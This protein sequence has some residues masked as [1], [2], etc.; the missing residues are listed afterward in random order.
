MKLTKTIK[1]EV[2]ETV[3]IFCN[4]C[5]NSCKKEHGFYGLIETSFSSGYESIFPD[6]Y[7]YTFSLCEGCLLKM[8][9]QFKIEAEAK[10]NGLL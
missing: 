10:Y 6:G 3:D 7:I 9:N 5:G 8:F 1:K 4:N 2:E